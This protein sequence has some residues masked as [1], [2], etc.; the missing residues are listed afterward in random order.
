MRE[1]VGYTSYQSTELDPELWQSYYSDDEPEDEDVECYYCEEPL[2][3]FSEDGLCED[4]FER[5]FRLYDS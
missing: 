2:D 5:K 1:S 3:E 4:C